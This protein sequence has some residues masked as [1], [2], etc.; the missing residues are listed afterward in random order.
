MAAR[1]SARVKSESS[2]PTPVLQVLGGV[3][4]LG[5]RR[6]PDGPLALASLADEGLPYGALTSTAKRLALSERETAESVGIPA[7]T[8]ARRRNKR[9]PR[10]E[11]ER[12]LNLARVIARALVVF[13]DPNKARDWLMSPSRALGRVPFSLVGSAFG[14]EALLAE[15]VRIEHGVFA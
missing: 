8:L 11:S 7:R 4:V 1:S 14:V 9:F 13:G 12:L 2:E 6:A 5:R 3:A 10:D 15:L